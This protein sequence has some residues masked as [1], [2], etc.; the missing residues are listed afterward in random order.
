MATQDGKNYYPITIARSDGRGY[1]NLDHNA[2][3]PND[4]KDVEQLER[5]Q[6]IIAHHLQFQLAPKGESE[7]L[8]TP[9]TEPSG[10]KLLIT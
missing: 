3:D 5:W 2:I 1:Q 4:D 7:S 8:P 9:F 10:A 6:V